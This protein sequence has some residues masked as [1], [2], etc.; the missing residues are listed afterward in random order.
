MNAVHLTGRITRDIELKQAG[1]HSVVQNSI[2]V[3]RSFPNRETG[4]YESDFFNFVAWR[5]Q[6]DVLANYAKK[7]DM[8]GLSGRLQSRNYENQQGQRV[9]VTEIVVENIDLLQPKESQNNG[10]FSQGG[11]YQGNSQGYNSNATG[12]GYG[13]Q[14]NNYVPDGQP[15]E[16][17]ED[18]LPF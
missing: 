18:D 5:G 3:R 13:S 8:I 1:Q 10:G 11:N 14:T 2:A 17:R 9:Y 6:A 15:V 7:G 16:I 12:G 4:E